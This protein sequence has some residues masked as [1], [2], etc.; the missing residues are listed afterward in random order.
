MS[1]LPRLPLI[2]FAAA[3]ALGAAE[4][5]PVQYWNGSQR[6][7]LALALDELDVVVGD[8]V[9][10]EQLK[11]VIP[12]AQVAAAGKR[13]GL[14]FPGAD[15]AALDLHLA[16]ARAAGAAP[17]AVLY[18]D[19][20]ARSAGRRQVLTDRLAIRLRP[21]QDI[22]PLVAKYRLKLEQRV[23]YSADT[24]IAQATD[25]GATAALVAAN[26]IYE[27]D[28]A[29]FAT[30][31]IERV[32]VLK[33]TPSDP[34]FAQQWHLLNS[35]QVGGV[36]NAGNDI[37]VAPVWDFV[38]GTGLGTGINVAV[39]DSGV[40]VA[41]PDLA[42]NCRTA[43][44]VDLIDNDGDPTPTNT[45]LSDFDPHGTVVAGL[46]AARDGN[47]LG[48]VGV[49][50]R[51]GI[52]GV[53]LT[54][55]AFS[56]AT[57]GSAVTW[58]LAPANPADRVHVNTNSWGPADDGATLQAPPALAVAARATG[59]ASGRGGR[60]IVYLWAAGNG[61]ADG[62]EAN[63]DGY[64]NSP[65]VIAVAASAPNGFGA[66]YSE[67]GACVFIEAPGGDFGG[68]GIV[69]TDTVGS[70][71]EVAGDYTATAD[72]LVGTSFATPIVAGVVALMLEA[73]PLLSWRDVRHI[74]ARTATKSASSSPFWIDNHALPAR[75]WNRYHG[76]GRV[77][78][79]AAVGAAQ[80]WLAAPAEATPLAA[81]GGGTGA[82]PDNNPTGRSG[83]CSISAPTGF[84]AE[85]VELHV[86]ITH[87]LRGQLR[88]VLTSPLGTPV[89]IAA[90]PNDLGANY[91]WIF[92]SVAS[93]GENPAGAWSLQVIDTSAATS[94]TKNGIG[95]LDS[96][97]LT[98]HGY[99]PH[100]TPTLSGASPV[101]A[102]TGS[103]AI[104]VTIAGTGFVA[105]VS[106][107]KWDGVV[108]PSTFVSATQLS[109]VIPAPDLAANGVHTIT[110]TNPDFDGGA[111][112][113][114]NGLVFRVSN[115]PGFSAPPSGTQAMTEDTPRAFT[116]TLTDP[117]AGDTLTLTA[118]AANAALF[119]PSG[120]VVT[121]TG[122][123]RTLT[124]TP[125]PDQNG[126]STITLTVSDGATSATTSFTA[127]VAAVNDPPVAFSGVFEARANQTL[128]ATLSG[129]DP[130]V[131]QTLTAIRL[132]DSADGTA[133]VSANG[134][135]T[136]QPT[137]GFTGVTSFTWRLSDGIATA[138]A[139]ATI[140]VMA[141]PSLPRPRI[142]SEPADEVVL[143]GGGTWSYVPTV[144]HTSATTLQVTAPASVSGGNTILWPIAAPASGN[145]VSFVIIARDGLTGALDYQQVILRYVPTGAPN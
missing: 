45:A 74:L 3:G 52:V 85:V 90:R 62:D 111:D 77:D 75:H 23:V 19:H 129:V 17:R 121:G 21:G 87:N 58:Q 134:A 122:T 79:A 35:G 14:R 2:M 6:V 61:D 26:R 88:F 130:D 97:S 24:W 25:P 142:T 40:E 47:G 12:G 132:V 81:T 59:T 10:V 106:Q 57:E 8:G 139:T 72:N 37:N 13:A 144:S 83:T 104:P 128:S 44:D 5:E 28:G 49:A 100:P 112:H 22:A 4:Q 118:T 54:A 70:A 73:N 67:G 116:L 55:G 114:S 38:G 99:V 56:D 91:D 102:A 39:V 84:R 50:P 16:A 98:V 63:Y 127:D 113:V 64:A 78:A 133:T 51:A 143:Q 68:A 138:D 109:V 126:T 33:G 125:L 36:G 66:S 34:L 123:T 115:P 136:F 76:F 82:I 137:P 48:G 107:V 18:P 46:V 15:R 119:A 103:A 80:G 95:S 93:W 94:G 140:V 9:A 135:F 29:L 131:G 32:M 27:V 145:H 92:T 30:P 1:N 53:R 105:D 65:Y 120:M 31:L 42:V 101:G 141:D 11:R 20:L 71:G 117:D 43:L 60:G 69:S 124:L 86:R 96:W 7:T 110:V 89:D 108:L 41:H